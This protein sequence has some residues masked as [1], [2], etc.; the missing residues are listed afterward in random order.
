MIPQVGDEVV[1]SFT[2]KVTAVFQSLHGID[3]IGI[4]TDQGIAHTFWP[5]EETSV[6][7]NTIVKG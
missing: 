4:V 2:G 6:V 1:L 7:I 5:A 3:A